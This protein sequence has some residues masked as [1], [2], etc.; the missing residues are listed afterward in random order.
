MALHTG[1]LLKDWQATVEHREIPNAA[2]MPSAY[3][4]DIPVLSANDSGSIFNNSLS[5]DEV[6]IDSLGGEGYRRR[7][8]RRVQFNRVSLTHPELPF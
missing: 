8:N 4:R 3:S 5:G 2:T 7:R 1:K 6:P